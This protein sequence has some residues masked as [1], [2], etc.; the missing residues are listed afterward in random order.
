MTSMTAVNGMLP[1]AY[2]IGSGADMLKPLAI[3][4]IGALFISVLFSP[5]AIPT[6]YFL[7]LP[8]LKTSTVLKIFI[9][10]KPKQPE[11]FAFDL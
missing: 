11:F 7:L 6:V 8:D 2:G 1:L 3:A 5:V 9:C 10:M 4:V